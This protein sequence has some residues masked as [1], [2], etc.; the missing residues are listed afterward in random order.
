MTT[1]PAMIITENEYLAEQDFF[2]FRLLSTIGFDPADVAELT[3]MSEIA[4]AEG[5]VSVDALCAVG[6]E[7]EDVYKIHTVPERINRVVVTAG[8]MPQKADECVL[9]A[10]LF[11]EDAIGTRI[12][13]TSAHNTALRCFCPILRR[14][15]DLSRRRRQGRILC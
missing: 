1:T 3:E 4:M 9:D 6:E 7:N 11:R 5:A 12:T 14:K 8:R 2:D 10:A 15:L 13:V